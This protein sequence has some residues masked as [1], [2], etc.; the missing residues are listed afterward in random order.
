MARKFLY[1]FAALIVLVIA[2]ALA[3][4]LFGTDLMRMA[5]T[6]GESF[7]RQASVQASAYDDPKL[8]LARPE[9]P[10]NPALWTPDGY[11]PRTAD[12]KGPKAA[13]FFIHPTSY[14]S[15]DHWNAPLDDRETNDRSALFLRGQASAFNAVGDVWA[16]RYRQATFGA[17]LT[18]VADSEQ[19][20]QLA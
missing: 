17:F 14:V 15:R 20:L 16:P 1:I 3:Y 19:A 7:R 9:I 18:S 4:R 5:L 11:A 6:P 12:A 13:I 2:A 10:G 8:W